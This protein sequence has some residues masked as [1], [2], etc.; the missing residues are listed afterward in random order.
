MNFYE[1]FSKT[2]AQERDDK[3][4]NGL[5]IS[6]WIKDFYGFFII[7]LISN[8]G[9]AGPCWRFALFECSC[10]QDRKKGRKKRRQMKILKRSHNAAAGAIS[11]PDMKTIMRHAMSYLRDM[12]CHN[13]KICFV[14]ITIVCCNYKI[15]YVVIMIYEIYFYFT[16]MTLMGFCRNKMRATH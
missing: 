12:P 14:V 6:I 2:V 10:L 13:Y 8:I 5:Q 3:I 16:Y 7:V 11:Q 9:A 1:I 4:L 15:V